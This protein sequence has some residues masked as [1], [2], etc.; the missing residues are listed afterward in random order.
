MVQFLCDELAPKIL[1]VVVE[2][3][4]LPAGIGHRSRP[5]K[6]CWHQLKQDAGISRSAVEWIFEV[7]EL[8]S[9]N[10][11]PKNRRGLS[12]FTCP[13]VPLS[14]GLETWGALA[15]NVLADGLGCYR[16]IGRL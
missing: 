13:G 12:A 11:E 14:R 3:G 15:S 16:R 8:L 2:A 10:N 6:R 9:S 5:F 7:F 1:V 4:N